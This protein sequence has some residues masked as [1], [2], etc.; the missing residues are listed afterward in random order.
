M[1]SYGPKLREREDGGQGGIS[2]VAE[3][4]PS[5]KEGGPGLW[6]EAGR[7]GEET[8]QRGLLCF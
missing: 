8:L 1:N 7:D 4:Q 5:T 6:P 3:G 2:Q